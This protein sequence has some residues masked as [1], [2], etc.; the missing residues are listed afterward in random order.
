MRLSELK[1]TEVLARCPLFQGVK[2]DKLKSLT[3]VCE[4]LELAKGQTLFLQGDPVERLC[5][6]AQ[7]LIKVL[8]L[9]PSGRKQVV[10]TMAGPGQCVAAVALFLGNPCYPATAEASE[11]SRILAIPGA[12]FQRLVQ[13]DHTLCYNLLRVTAQHTGQIVQVLDRM[14]FREVD[15]RLAEYLLNMAQ[16][17]GQSFKLPTNP[18][19]AAIVGTT[20]EPVSR[21]LGHFSRK[22]WVA[23]NR[24]RLHI[25]NLLALQKL[26]R[27][28]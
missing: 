18:E 12:S 7:G 6:V 9:D 4:W 25:T 20:S 17:H 24:R 13:Q 26:A 16:D 15:S 27:A 28:S 1:P 19:I 22:G 11:P 14:V 8:R 10:M 3:T 2:P 5:L 23:I 21:K